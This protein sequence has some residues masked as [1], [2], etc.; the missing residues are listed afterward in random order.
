M[1]LI[2]EKTRRQTR[3]N[4]DNPK[5]KQYC[6]RKDSHT[7]KMGRSKALM[8]TQGG[9]MDEDAFRQSVDGMEK[10]QMLHSRAAFGARVAKRAIHPPQHS[11]LP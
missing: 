8:G 2:A 1:P 7:K 3:P 11:P 9:K 5:R 4:P 10:F 6:V